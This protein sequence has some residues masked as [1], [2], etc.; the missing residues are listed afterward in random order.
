MSRAGPISQYS[1][2]YSNPPK[3]GLDDSPALVV[4]E[5]GFV[6][7]D[8]DAGRAAKFA[9]IEPEGPIVPGAD[10]AAVFDDARREIAPG[11]GAAAVDHGNIAASKEDSQ[12]VSVDLDVFALIRRQLF[13]IT[14]GGPSHGR[15]QGIR[16]N[17]H[18]N[19][20]R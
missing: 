3:I 5:P 13:Q 17:R 8:R 7:R 2:K 18:F 4:V 6:A 20:D 10:R 14:E 12:V 16:R 11:V 1:V 15:V 9:V 19:I